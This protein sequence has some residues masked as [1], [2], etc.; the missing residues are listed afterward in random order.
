MGGTALF[1]RSPVLAR[2]AAPPAAAAPPAQ[3]GPGT[4]ARTGRSWRWRLLPARSGLCLGG[5]GLV[6]V[7]F[8]QARHDPAAVAWIEAVQSAGSALGGLGYGAVTWRIPAGRRLAGLTAGLAAVLVPAALSPGLIVLALLVALA[9]VLVAPA[10]ATAYVLAD[11]L[12]APN[13]RNRAGNW[14]SSGF[15]AGSAAGSALSGQLVG[16]IPLGACL[17]VLAAPAVLAVVPLLRRRE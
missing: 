13:A 1:L 6:I 16:R 14:V 2:W 7:A 17:P 15:N 12:A 10:L 3:S 5:L 4:A 8:S 11:S 9:G